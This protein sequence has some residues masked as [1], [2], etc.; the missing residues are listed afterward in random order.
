VTVIALA[1]VFVDGR[2]LKRRPAAVRSAALAAVRHHAAV[3]HHPLR[4]HAHRYPPRHFFS[5]LCLWLVLA[6]LVFMAVIGVSG[7]P[8][9]IAYL[10]GAGR[11]ATFTAQSY[12]QTCTYT[13]GVICST[14]TI[15]VLSRPGAADVS[16]AIWPSQVPLGQSF[17]VREP[18]W[19]FGLGGA[20]IGGK[21]TAIVAICLSLLFDFFAVFGL[22][23]AVR[24]IR[25]WLADRRA[26]RRD[27]QLA[28]VP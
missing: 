27:G 19:S 1:V 23:W 28:A 6:L 25:S 14:E 15:G 9:G 8:D 12:Q 10:A 17:P 20:M 26:R 21:S 24:L 18:V 22:Y 4:A 7:L 16:G 13:N 3:A 2:L 5:F 11:N